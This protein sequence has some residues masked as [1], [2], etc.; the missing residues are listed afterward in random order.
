[1]EGEKMVHIIDLYSFEPAHW[2]NLLQMLSARPEG[3]SHLRITG[4][5]EQ[6]EVLDNMTFRLTEEAEKLD[7]PF[8][9]N[10]IVSKLEN[11]DLE[12]LRKT[13]EALAVSSVLRLHS[14]LENEN[15]ILGTNS[16]SASKSSNPNQ[17]RRGL[18]MGHRTLGEWLEKDGSYV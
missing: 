8:Q 2:L 9:F 1:M 11:I 4:I 15:E 5:H 17:L 12:S 3:A 18:Q 14:L 16:P 6:K 10:P 7:I 13:E